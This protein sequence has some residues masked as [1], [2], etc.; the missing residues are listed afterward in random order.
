MRLD[1][2]AV[3]WDKVDMSSDM[4]YWGSEYGMEKPWKGRGT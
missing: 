2:A 4:Y 3:D 1:E